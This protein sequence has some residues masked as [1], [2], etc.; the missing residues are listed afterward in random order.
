MDSLNFNSVESIP[1]I[2]ARA[3]FTVN[4]ACVFK[5]DVDII[6]T[7]LSNT[8]SYIPWGDDNQMSYDIFELVDMDETLPPAKSSTLGFAMV[9]GYVTTLAPSYLFS[10]CVGMAG[11]HTLLNIFW[12]VQRRPLHPLM[13]ISRASWLFSCHASRCSHPFVVRSDGDLAGRNTSLPC[14]PTPSAHQCQ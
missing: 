12:L 9:Q 11:C 1:S 5:E 2:E 13:F 7:I 8:L 14:R 3:A 10:G 6:P 4:S